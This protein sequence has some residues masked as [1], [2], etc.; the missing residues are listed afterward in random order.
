MHSEFEFDLIAF[1]YTLSD[2][3]GRHAKQRFP[4]Y[5]MTIINL[6]L[7]L[8]PLLL[9]LSFRIKDDLFLW[10]MWN[11]QTAVDGLEMFD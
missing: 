6:I 11:L 9:I 5:L 10:L 3:F 8:N 4:L 7:N 2:L 1:M